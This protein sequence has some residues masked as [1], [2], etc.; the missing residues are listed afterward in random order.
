MISTIES[1]YSS[2]LCAFLGLAGLLLLIWPLSRRLGALPDAWR[3]AWFLFPLGLALLA[4]AVAYQR[5]SSA[6]LGATLIIA[7]VVALA[8]ATAV[9]LERRRK[10]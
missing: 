8:L 9:I 7:A 1:L 3:R 5:L 6:R 10:R 2:A 4:A